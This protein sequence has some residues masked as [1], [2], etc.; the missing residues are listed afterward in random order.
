[1]KDKLS[2]ARHCL[3]NR[4]K[5]KTL[6]KKGITII[7]VSYNIQNEITVNKYCKFAKYCQIMYQVSL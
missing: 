2:Q 7:L 4:F 3:F 5:L 1:M 6:Q